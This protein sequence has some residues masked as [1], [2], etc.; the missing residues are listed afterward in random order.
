MA[1]EGFDICL[2]TGRR[3]PSGFGAL[4][5]LFV[6]GLT[7]SERRFTISKRVEYGAVTGAWNLR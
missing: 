3:G 4:F 6:D 2:R 7:L 1:S 5:G